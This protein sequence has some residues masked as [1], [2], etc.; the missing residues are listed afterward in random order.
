MWTHHLKTIEFL[1]YQSPHYKGP[2]IKMGAGVQAFEAYAAADQRG[3]AVVGGECSTV[4][5]A[6][7]YTQGGGH[8]ALSSTY[9]MGA[10]QT[11]EWEVVTGEGQLITATRTQNSDMYWALS[12]G[13]GGTYGVVYS[14]TS[15]AHRDIPVAGLNLT[16]SSA[17]I[18]ADTFYKAVGYY[19]SFLPNVTR[20][21]GMSIYLVTKSSF[22]IAPITFP[23]VSGAIEVQRLLQ[24]FTQYLTH[25]GIMYDLHVTQ[26]PG[27]LSE[28]KAMFPPSLTKVGVSLYGG[29]LIPYSVIENQNDALTAVVR[30]ITEG[31]GSI[32]GIGVDV[33]MR[34]AGDVYNAVLPTWRDTVVDL[35]L[36]S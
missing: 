15:K 18:S 23:G 5:L 6:G 28:Y 36:S 26:F 21:G 4:G 19:H 32:Y 7:G 3:L 35:V 33:S 9:G 12:G 31:G 11:L 17:G 34:V 2:A 22:V 27:Y 13:G 29:R 30:N 20:A 16:F 25:L 10:D 24:P 14:L 1:D 8:S